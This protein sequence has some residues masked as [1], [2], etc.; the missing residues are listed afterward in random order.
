M[1]QIFLLLAAV[2]TLIIILG[3]LYK[4]PKEA[5]KAINNPSKYLNQT[6]QTT[7]GDKK[8][9]KLGDTEIITEIADTE[10]E[11]E[12]G[13][14]GRKSLEENQGMLFVF[15]KKDFKPAFWM[16]GM[17][18]SLDFIWIND[19]K[20]SQIDQNI[21]PPETNTPDKN[22]PY[23]IPNG[24]IDYVLEVNAGFTKKYDIRVGATVDLSSL[25]E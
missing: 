7:V 2:T 5:N 11:R 17:L 6:L 19:G 3:V 23:Y 14:S 22:L 15:E 20:I 24:L 21:P 12:K 18:I 13:L 4:Y 10:P 16:K 8:T 25:K 9:I 1:K